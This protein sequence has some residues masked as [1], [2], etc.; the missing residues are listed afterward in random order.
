MRKGE[1]ATGSLSAL[2]FLAAFDAYAGTGTSSWLA[3]LCLS[4]DAPVPMIDGMPMEN[5]STHAAYFASAGLTFLS[6]A[7]GWEYTQIQIAKLKSSEPLGVEPKRI[8]AAIIYITSAAGCG[9]QRG[10]DQA[11]ETAIGHRLSLNE[12]KDAY[13]FL[14]RNEAPDIHRI[15]AG[16]SEKERRTLLRA[17]VLTWASNGMDP[18][19][20]T[21]V[22][23]R[24]VALLGFTQDDICKTLDRIWLKERANKGL[25]T[26]YRL[27]KSASLAAFRTARKASRITMHALA[28]HARQLKTRAFTAIER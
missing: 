23:E 2:S 12:A 16:A 8:L 6:A 14:M 1:I 3:D 20:A 19:P 24:L 4:G 15:F 10:V 17:V 28:P 7:L 9:N 27:F 18:E 13:S 11:F 5:H 26:S 22:T 25:H 21:R